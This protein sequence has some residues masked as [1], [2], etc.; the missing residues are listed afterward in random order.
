MVW[1]QYFTFLSVHIHV[2]SKDPSLSLSL[3]LS[4]AASF[5]ERPQVD[6]NVYGMHSCVFS[7]S[8]TCH[9]PHLFFSFSSTPLSRFSLSY[10]FL[11][12]SNCTQFY[13]VM[14]VRESGR[15]V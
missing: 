2:R 13:E 10:L 8:H 12:T 9:L 6:F 11:S 14:K 7:C 5:V 3:S 1:V 4:V 15:G